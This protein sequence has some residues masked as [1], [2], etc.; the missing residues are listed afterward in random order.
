MSLVDVAVVGGVDVDPG[1]AN[2]SDWKFEVP[3]SP[4]KLH[5]FCW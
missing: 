3:E 4:G 5:P 2:E 1:V